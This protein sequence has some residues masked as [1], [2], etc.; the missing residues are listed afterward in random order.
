MEFE[1]APQAVEELFKMMR[2]MVMAY[3]D[4]KEDELK[5]IANFRRTTIQLYLTSL[6]ARTSWQTLITYVHILAIS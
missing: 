6:D 5:A 3:P 1:L 4:S 2:L